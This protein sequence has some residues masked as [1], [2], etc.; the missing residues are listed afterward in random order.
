MKLSSKNYNN[1]HPSI[2]FEQG[3]QMIYSV[4]GSYSE[5]MAN[6]DSISCDRVFLYGQDDDYES[7]ELDAGDFSYMDDDLSGDTGNVYDV[8]K[9]LPA[10]TD[11]WLHIS[12]TLR[13]MPTG[14]FILM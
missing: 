5:R 2:T 10:P 14:R 4:R 6:P 3:V 9:H 13:M 12:R 8:A 11:Q 1:K 7:D